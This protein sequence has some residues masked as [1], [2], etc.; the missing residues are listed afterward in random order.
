M[1]YISFSFLLFLEHFF[2]SS[3]RSDYYLFLDHA[4]NDQQQVK[5]CVASSFSITHHCCH[6]NGI[7]S[8]CCVITVIL[9]NQILRQLTTAVVVVFVLIFHII[10]LFVM[11]TV[12]SSWWTS[13]KGRWICSWFQLRRWK[14]AATHS[15]PTACSPFY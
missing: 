4:V 14:T 12:M 5:V 3:N 7:L 6:L 13:D 15:A 11:I 9:S 10:Q 2:F 8:C 1:K